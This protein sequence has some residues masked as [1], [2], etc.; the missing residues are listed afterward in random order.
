MI[1]QSHGSYGIQFKNYIFS[2]SRLDGGFK[3]YFMFTSTW[4]N[5]PI[6]LI[7][8]QMG[9]NHQLVEL[10]WNLL[11][12]LNFSGIQLDVL[13]RVE[14]RQWSNE[15]RSCNDYFNWVWVFKWGRNSWKIMKPLIW[16][17]K[18]PFC[19]FGE[20]AIWSFYFFLLQSW[21]R[22]TSYLWTLWWSFA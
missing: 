19:F 9:W 2:Y 22:F 14:L 7:F 21:F 8:F 4:G 20:E 15:A 5:G 11:G 18:L 10:F 13:D 17:G 6:W 12:F 1:Y 3:Y 16:R